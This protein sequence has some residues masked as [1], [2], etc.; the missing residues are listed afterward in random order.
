MPPLTAGPP[1]PLPCSDGG[2]LGDDAQSGHNYD[3][4]HQYPVKKLTLQ[5][6]PVPP[7]TNYCAG[8]L[9]NGEEIR[10]SIGHHRDEGP[11]ARR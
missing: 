8:V 3:Y 6:K 7:K 9:S 11:I 4:G 5:A 1:P 2:R 10:R